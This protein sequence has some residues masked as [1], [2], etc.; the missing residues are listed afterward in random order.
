MRRVVRPDGVVGA[1]MWLEG[2]ALRMG[3]IFWESAAT[4][5]PGVSTREGRMA[6]RKQGDIA[7]LWKRT[8]LR[9]VEETFLDVRARYE[10]FDDFWD[11]IATAAGAIGSYMVAAGAARRDVIREA[12]RARLGDPRQGFELAGRA[13]AARGKV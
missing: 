10:S 8:G 2:E 13:C 6:F 1:C 9:D 7:D 12:C 11:G 5:D 4:V 3:Q